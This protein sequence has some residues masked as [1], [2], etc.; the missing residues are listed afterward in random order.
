M[1]FLGAEGG[2]PGRAASL[3][4][5]HFAAGATVVSLASVTLVYLTA[6]GPA[7]AVF[8]L[9]AFT[10]LALVMAVAAPRLALPGQAFGAANQVTLARAVLVSLIAGLLAPSAPGGY[11]AAW[12][13]VAIAAT[14]LSLDG[15]D[16][17]LAR[18]S[19][20]VS[21]FGARFDMETDA[22]L[23]LVLSLLVFSFDKAGAWIIAA[24]GARYAFLLTGKALPQLRGTLPPR[25][26]RQAVCVLLIVALTICLAPVVEQPF[27]GVVA[28]IAV[29]AVAWSF[30][31]DIVWLWR[32]PK[33]GDADDRFA[34]VGRG[35]GGLRPGDHLRMG[36]A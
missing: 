18:R 5:M 36:G 22:L 16:G 25:W 8:S 20:R 14:A 9:G 19:G 23:A 27:S 28:A 31:V 11:L 4:A 34:M 6:V 2:R 13:A 32:R 1:F 21:S 17:W 7:F 30:A 3:A 10:G 12:A 35:A 33:H 26:R 24:G 15:V 29:M